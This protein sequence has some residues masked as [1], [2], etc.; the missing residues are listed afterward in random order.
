LNRFHG[1]AFHANN[2]VWILIGGIIGFLAA[3]VLESYKN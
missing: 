1:S 3:I 2:S